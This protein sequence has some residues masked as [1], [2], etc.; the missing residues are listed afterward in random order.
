MADFVSR[1]AG[2]RGSW[3]FSG[4]R[5][6]FMR[7][8]RLLC[9][10]S[11]TDFRLYDRRL[12]VLYHGLEKPLLVSRGNFSVFPPRKGLDRPS[13]H[14]C[15]HDLPFARAVCARDFPKSYGCCLSAMSFDNFFY[16]YLTSEALDR[17]AFFRAHH[18]QQC[19][20]CMNERI[21]MTVRALSLSNKLW[22]YR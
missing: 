14:S 22:M 19:P 10:A 3:Q 5:Y 8:F 20:G 18:A 4:Q 21:E 13:I 15:F 9:H 6:F 17:V 16:L 11:A 12:E 2:A 1:I 7:V